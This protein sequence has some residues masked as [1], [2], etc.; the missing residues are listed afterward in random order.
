MRTIKSWLL[1]M[2]FRKEFLQTALFYL[3]ASNEENWI[4]D[5]RHTLHKNQT[6]PQIKWI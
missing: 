5:N 2:L 6:T 3:I 1:Y 4:D